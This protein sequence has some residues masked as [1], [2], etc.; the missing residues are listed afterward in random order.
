M[1]SGARGQRAGRGRSAP[2]RWRPRCDV[3]RV[4]ARRAGGPPGAGAWR[5]DSPSR[6]GLKEAPRAPAPYL[7]SESCRSH[8]RFLVPRPGCGPPGRRRHPGARRRPG[9]QA[10]RRARA[11]RQRASRA[12]RRP[13]PCA[14]VRAPPARG[15]AAARARDGP[16]ARARR[17]RPRR[18]PRLPRPARARGPPPLPLPRPR[19]SRP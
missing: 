4:Q 17:C 11:W 10:R 5:P 7:R 1:R 12:T 9:R 6:Q 2:R 18:C 3:A 19:P 14:C 13:R 15:R 8:P 16:R